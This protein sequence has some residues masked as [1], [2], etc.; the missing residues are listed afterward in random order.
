MVPKLMAISSQGFAF[1][2]ILCGWGWSGGR[3]MPSFPVLP[4][5]CHCS[6]YSV[7]IGQATKQP[8][9]CQSKSHR[10]GS[11]CPR[12]K[13]MFVI[14]WHVMG[15]ATWTVWQT[16]YINC[17]KYIMRVRQLKL[18]NVKIFH[19][20]HKLEK[21]WA[22]SCGNIFI[23]IPLENSPSPMQNL[24]ES[25]QHSLVHLLIHPS[26]HSSINHLL[27]VECFLCFGLGD[28]G[29]LFGKS[30]Q[31]VMVDLGKPTELGI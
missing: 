25:W 10:G 27:I 30:P 24:L 19:G 9:Q 28:T 13:S 8:A 18:W 26:I 21:L 1:L 20:S 11:W 5:D 7:A 17:E 12:A 4:R 3:T 16:S 29:T 2:L 14:M 23:K 15:H 22:P 31:R 6:S